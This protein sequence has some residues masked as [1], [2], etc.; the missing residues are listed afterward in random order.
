MNERWYSLAGKKEINAFL[1][2]RLTLVIQDDANTVE[3]YCDD[4]SQASTENFFK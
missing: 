4:N 2:L 1:T 3:C